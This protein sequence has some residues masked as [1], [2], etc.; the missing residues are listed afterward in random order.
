[1]E[2]LTSNQER[3]ILQAILDD[4]LADHDNG[5]SRV[6]FLELGE[7]T[8]EVLREFNIPTNCVI[9]VNIGSAGCEQSRQE[10]EIFW[11]AYE[12]Y[13]D[14]VLATIYAYGDVIQIMEKLQPCNFLENVFDGCYNCDESGYFKRIS[15]Y[16]EVYEYIKYTSFL[17]ELDPLER[18]G[19]LTILAEKMLDYLQVIC[20]YT[21]TC[22]DNY[23][24]GLDAE[25]NIKSYDYGFIKA[26]SEEYRDSH[27]FA[28]DSDSI[29]WRVD[30]YIRQIL[31]L[32]YFSPAGLQDIALEF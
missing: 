3:R 24:V 6:V 8:N 21:G 31:Q 25:G 20:R 14:N 27:C 17:K 32:P 13:D 22:G 7:N 28:G 29:A 26:D 23:Q 10:R 5:S 19:R 15:F 30:S 1:M 18:E 2:K 12:N 4:S 9:K 16:D 11:E